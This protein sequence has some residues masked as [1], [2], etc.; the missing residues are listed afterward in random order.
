M[1]LMGIHSLFDTRRRRAVEEAV[2]DD[3]TLPGIKN[4]RLMAEPLFDAG[5]A[6]QK[7]EH[8]GKAEKAAQDGAPHPPYQQNPQPAKDTSTTHNGVDDDAYLAQRGARFQ[9]PPKTPGRVPAPD[10]RTVVK[11]SG[12]S[13]FCAGYFAYTANEY[14]LLGIQYNDSDAVWRAIAGGADINH[15]FVMRPV[16]PSN[17]EAHPTRHVY[18]NEKTPLSLAYECERKELAQYLVS[19][20]AKE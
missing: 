7:D 10:N 11:K 17:R 19:M 20:G 15:K 13:Q 1:I 2:R 16:N 18:A 14:L 12:R 4:A 6:A 9:K 8:P 5:S 3:K